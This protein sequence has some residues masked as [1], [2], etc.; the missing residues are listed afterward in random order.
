[1]DDVNCRKSLCFGVYRWGH[2][3]VRDAAAA[4]HPIGKDAMLPLALSKAIHYVSSKSQHEVA[5]DR[6][7]TLSHW[8]GRAKALIGE[9]KAFHDS[10][11]S[12]VQSILMPKRLLLWR[13]MLLHYDFPDLSVFDE[14]VNGTDLVGAV[15]ATPYFDASFKPAKMTV[16]ELGDSAASIRK[17]AMFYFSR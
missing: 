15:P 2:E 5:I 13:E 17:S 12:G 3:F 9:E 16:K 7:H 11:A 10:L 14:V 1:M 8:L 4:G 6:H